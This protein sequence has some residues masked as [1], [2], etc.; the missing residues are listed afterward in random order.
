MDENNLRNS[1]SKLVA[2]FISC[3]RKSS[4][5]PVNHPAVVAALEELHAEFTQ[6]LKIKKSLT[7]DDK[8]LVEGDAVEERTTLIEQSISYFKKMNIENLTFFPGLSQNELD[9]LIKIILID[10]REIKPG[11]DLKKILLDKNI[12]DVQI[13][14]FSYVKIEKDKEVLVEKVDKAGLDKLKSKIA[15]LA[16]G[17]SSQEESEAIADEVF[18]IAIRELKEDKAVSLA[19]RNLLKKFLAHYADMQAGLLRLK[20]ALVESGCPVQAADTFLQKLGT[21]P[22]KPKTKKEPSRDNGEYASLSEENQELKSKIQELEAELAERA[23]A[24]NKIERNV[25][26]ILDDKERMDNVVHNMSDGLVVVDPHGKILMVNPAAEALLGV[27]T[28]DI[29]RQLKDAVKDEHLLALVK[30]A[31]SAKDGV[32]EKDV[33]LFSHNESTMRVLRASSALVEDQNGKTVGMVA[34]LNDITKQKE[35]EK[36]KSDFVAKVSHEIRTP[37]IAVEKSLALILSKS[38]GPLSSDQDRFL[39]IAERNLQRLNLLINDLLDLS[40][41]EAGKVSLSREISSVTKIIEESVSAFGNWAETKTLKIERIVSENL[42]QLNVDVNRIIQ[43]INNLLSNA[44]KFTPEN[45]TITVEAK[46]REAREI[47]ISVK[48]TGIGIPEEALP[49]L[50][51]KF[52]QVSGNLTTDI[53]GTGIGLA[54]AKEIVELHGGKI[55]V[56]SEVGKGTRFIFSLP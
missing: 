12:K 24:I 23:E 52:Y 37:L 45:G 41:L 44:I 33:E 38:T 55:R 3:L 53:R 27:S 32:V 42:P 20:T 29:G 56:E 25:K 22:Q 43:V 11:T 34:I 36:L 35:V 40:K 18:Q 39:S 10:T 1:Y 30:N 5:Y 48:D 50:F 49:K 47:E 8:I 54:I 46:L 4:F 6:I 19:T 51:T 26:N 15:S 31:P 13:N 28:Q 14:Q 17:K 2:D 21:D 9:G 16:V 7:L